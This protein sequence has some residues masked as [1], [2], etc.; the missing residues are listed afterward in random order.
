M[1]VSINLDDHMHVQIQN[2]NNNKINSNQQHINQITNSSMEMNNTGVS[3]NNTNEI[4]VFSLINLQQATTASM[5]CRLSLNDLSW[6]LLKKPFKN[7]NNVKQ[8][9]KDILEELKSNVFGFLL[10]L[11]KLYSKTNEELV[12][13][14]SF[15]FHRLKKTEQFRR[16]S[17]NNK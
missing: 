16:L 1:D 5:I 10:L 15:S 7:T 3:I 17:S 4:D 2:N 13:L 6:L 11:C 14:L 9:E 12:S 8:Q